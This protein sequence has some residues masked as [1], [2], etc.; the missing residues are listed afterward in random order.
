MLIQW[1]DITGAN[2]VAKLLQELDYK[3]TAMEN[4]FTQ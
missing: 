3:T 4:I 1:C 2:K